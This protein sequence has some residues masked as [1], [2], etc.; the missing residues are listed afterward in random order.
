MT[1]HFDQS[2]TRFRQE[3]SKF[4]VLRLLQRFQNKCSI[5]LK[6][7]ANS[8]NEILTQNFKVPRKNI[9]KNIQIVSL[10]NSCS[11][12]KLHLKS[13]ILKEILETFRSCQVKGIS[14]IGLQGLEIG[15]YD[16]TRTN[17]ASGN[18]DVLKANLYWR[19]LLRFGSL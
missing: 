13:S 9:R 14:V 18:R 5:M 11:S 1:S 16:P 6:F 4:W 8:V 17:P 3:N 2:S 15:M 10:L 19:I 7:C 12:F